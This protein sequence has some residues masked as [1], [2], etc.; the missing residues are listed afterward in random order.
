M[1][2]NSSRCD[3][4]EHWG[5]FIASHTAALAQDWIKKKRP[6]FI[7]KSEWPTNSPD[8]NPLDCHVWG[9]MLG[10]NT[11]PRRQLTFITETFEL[12]T[13]KLCKVWF[14]ITEY[15][16][17]DCMFT[18]KS[19]ILIKFAGYVAW[20]LTC[21]HCKFGEKICSNSRDI[22]FFLRDYFFLARPVQHWH[23]ICYCWEH[24]CTWTV[25]TFFGC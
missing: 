19:V 14:I 21:K 23:C 11:V 10:L 2:C 6:G 8:L 7:G 24:T 5:N 12:L 15:S 16:G 25:I 17:R 9:A 4:L 22:E 20:I 3:N 1:W 13:K 18:W